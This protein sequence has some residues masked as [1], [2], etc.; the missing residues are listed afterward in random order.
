MGDVMPMQAR[1]SWVRRAQLHSIL[2]IDV[3]LLCRQADV[4]SISL[5]I[6]RDE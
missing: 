6:L 4:F 5:Y 1:Q 2:H 3:F